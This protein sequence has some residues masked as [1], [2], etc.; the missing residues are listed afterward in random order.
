[1]SVKTY[2]VPISY[3]M[4]GYVEV[5]ASSIE[6]AIEKAWDDDYDLPEDSHYVDDSWRVEEEIFREE[7]PE[8]N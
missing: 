2:K 5:E 3:E 6:E 1:M 8:E 4:Y 7:Y